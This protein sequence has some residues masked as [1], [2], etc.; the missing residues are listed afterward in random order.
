MKKA[1]FLLCCLL[2]LAFTACGSDDEKHA[3]KNAGEN[4]PAAPAAEPSSASSSA[5]E[6]VDAAPPAPLP[7]A[8]PEE[9]ARADRMVDFHNTAVAALSGGWYA[10]PDALLNN[11]RAYLEDW[12]LAAR[13]VVRGARGD[14]AR[15]LAPAKGLFPTEEEA[16]LAQWVRDMDKA[17]DSMLADYKSLDR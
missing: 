4:A 11:A 10:L 1:L 8:T 9:K 3:E 14:A 16:Q 13:P 6:A 7:P 5:P 2:I 17:L 12:R 15:A